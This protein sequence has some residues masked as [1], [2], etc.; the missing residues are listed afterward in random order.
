MVALYVYDIYLTQ[1]RKQYMRYF[2]IAASAAV[3]VAALLMLNLFRNCCSLYIIKNA[4]ARN[5][6]IQR[7]FV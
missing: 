6:S 1:Y 5:I 4:I 3:A 7:V 2:R